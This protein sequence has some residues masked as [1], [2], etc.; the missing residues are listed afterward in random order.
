MK[1]KSPH[2]KRPVPSSGLSVGLWKGTV[3]ML[4]FIIQAAGSAFYVPVQ[5]ELTAS[6][7]TTNAVASP[8]PEWVLFATVSNVD[9]YYQITDCSGKN[10]VLLKF[11]NRNASK[12]K[13]SWKEV[14]TTQFE[15]D[16]SGLAGT[17]QLLVATGET[18]EAACSDVKIKE[19]VILPS[20]VNPAYSADIK[21]FSFKDIVVT[22][23]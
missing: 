10:V 22:N 6:Q 19:L 15:K 4:L 1:M 7:R 2:L 12:V 17:K 14:F 16:K 11:N 9:F 20:Q 5:A 18:F 23:Q 13:V 8:A 21:K 3:L